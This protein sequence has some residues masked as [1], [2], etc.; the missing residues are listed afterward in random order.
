MKSVSIQPRFLVLVLGAFLW[1]A[2]LSGQWMVHGAPAPGQPPAAHCLQDQA[3][4]QDAQCERCCAACVQCA[5]A[6]VAQVVVR[7]P[8]GG[9]L[10]PAAATA[11]RETPPDFFLKPPRSRRG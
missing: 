1:W 3:P 11:P 7:P 6:A 8:H 4:C 9:A 2:P 5:Q 10:S